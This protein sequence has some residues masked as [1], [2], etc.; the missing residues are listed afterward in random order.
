M[1]ELCRTVEFVTIGSKISLLLFAD[2]L[3]L[4]TSSESDLHHVLNGFPSACDIAGMKIS[5]S[6][7]VVLHLSKN[8]V[9]CLCAIWWCIIEA[10]G[11]VQVTFASDGRQ[12][13]RISCSTRQCK[14]AR[15]VVRALH[16]SVVLKREQWRKA[17]LSL[18]KSIFVLNL[19]CVHE[20]LV[21]TERVRLQMQA[22]F[23]KLHNTAIREL[24]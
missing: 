10:G 14:N 20:F 17:K 24:S 7:I 3:V 15:V 13:L 6:K 8:P 21:I 23:D 9:Q 16:H 4:L 2:D 19:S 12:G 18:F 22:M 11:E 1:D 5:T